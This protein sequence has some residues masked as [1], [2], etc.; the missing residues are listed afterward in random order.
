MW[1]NRRY[2][3]LDIFY[4]ITIELDNKFYERKIKKNPKKIYYRPEPGK[5]FKPKKSQN[6]Y[7]NQSYDPMEFDATKKQSKK[8]TPKGQFKKKKS[9][10]YYNCGKPGYIKRNCRQPNKGN[11]HMEYAQ[12]I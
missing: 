6:N 8:K 1:D 7:F 4:K 10:K 3:E 5:S 9:V 12:A 11:Q 2:D